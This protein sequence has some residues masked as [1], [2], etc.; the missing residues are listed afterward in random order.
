M[1][2]FAQNSSK[3]N[4]MKYELIQLPYEANALES[5]ISKETLGFHHGKHLQA[6]VNN[7]NGLI[8]GTKYEEMPLEEIVKTADGGVFNNAGQILN[9]NLYF[10]QFRT[11]K[12][13]N[14]PTGVIA[15]WI[16][17]QFGSFEAFKEEFT[18]KGAT[19]FGS[20]WVWLSVDKEGKLVITQETNA[21]NPVQKGLRPLL[22]FDVWEH[23]YYID[24]Q[25]R[26]PDHLNA[27]WQIINWDMV[28]ERL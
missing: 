16:D 21:G 7:L 9:H 6:Y 26:R 19:L 24:Y 1:F 20:G 27:L 5:V 13:D 14:Q 25:N 18:K 15:Q 22:T 12:A 23:A 17:Q 8:E 2:I 11:P 3:R 10:T 28:N 4:D